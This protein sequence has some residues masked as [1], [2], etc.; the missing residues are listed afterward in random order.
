MY[1]LEHEAFCEAIGYHVINPRFL[2]R[3]DRF[4]LVFNKQ[5]SCVCAFLELIDITDKEAFVTIYFDQKTVI[6]FAPS[7]STAVIL[8][9]LELF[10]EGERILDAYLEHTQSL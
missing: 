3:N 10:K 6:E 7:P 1:P 5:T 4:S 2:W 9:K 8:E